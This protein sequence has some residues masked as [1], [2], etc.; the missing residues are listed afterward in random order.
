MD[1]D[2]K[3]PSFDRPFMPPEPRTGASLWRWIVTLAALAVLVVVAYQ[4]YLWLEGDV[5]RRRALAVQ[6][7][8]TPPLSAAAPTV[9]SSGS[10]AAAAPASNL[11]SAGDPLAPAVVGG[12]NKCL[13]GGEVVYTNA[14]CPAGSSALTNDQPALVAAQ[15]PAATLSGDADPVQHRADCNFLTAE[16]ARLDYEFHQSL[17]PPVLDD[18]STQLADLRRRADA[19]SCAP[20]AR[21]AADAAPPERRR[22][23]G[24]PET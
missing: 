5:A 4:A 15:P 23:A 1:Q 19:L 12:I 21:P 14:S 8:E 3:E 24:R 16:V 2:R 9:A 18:I 7:S 17:P 22:G 20:P 10:V 11:A 13:V 6:A